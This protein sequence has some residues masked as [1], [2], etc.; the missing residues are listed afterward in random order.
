MIKVFT[1]AKRFLSSLALLW[2]IQ[3]YALETPGITC[4]E[5]FMIE[6]Q[7]LVDAEISDEEFNTF[8]T[9]YYSDIVRNVP[10]IVL[11]RL[12]AVDSP[13]KLSP[14][15]RDRLVDTLTLKKLRKNWANAP[16]DSDEKREAYLAWK[17]FESEIEFS[18]IAHRKQG[19][20]HISMLFS[21]ASY[22][23]ENW[24]NWNP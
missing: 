22:V 9:K 16:S 17:S 23:W 19:V 5:T 10:K 6:S 4:L 18:D 1:V 13:K 14:F 21:Q 20:L 12:C 3:S 15:Y 2:T 24:R 8:I 7:I 11:E